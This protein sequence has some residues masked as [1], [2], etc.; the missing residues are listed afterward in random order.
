MS[1]DLHTLKTRSIV[2]QNADNSFPAVGG[3]LTVVDDRGTIRGSRDIMVNRVNFR[4]GGSIDASGN[5]VATS[6]TLDPNRMAFRSVSNMSAH[7]GSQ[8]NSTAIQSVGD[9]SV[10]NG[11]IYITGDQNTTGY[12]ETTKVKLL[13]LSSSITDT[14]LY[15]N[16]GDLL[17]QRDSLIPVNITN[18]IRSLVVEAGYR[19]FV[20]ITSNADPNLVTTVNR[21]LQLF[22]KRKIFLA[23]A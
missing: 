7:V 15:V 5:I 9:M 4:E 10:Q 8:T 13:D 18:G 2:L 16:I 6:L 12:L 20:P 17:W 11:N 23:L 14:S 1:V 21:L 19:D 22:N 3:V